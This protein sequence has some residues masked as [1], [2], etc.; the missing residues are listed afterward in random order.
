MLSKCFINDIQATTLSM[1]KV[2]G[3]ICGR[4]DKGLLMALPIDEKRQSEQ[5][6]N[7]I[8]RIP[9]N[10]ERNRK[11]KQKEFYDI[12]DI[13]RMGFADVDANSGYFFDQGNIPGNER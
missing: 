5:R 11:L 9:E 13:C 12:L 1:V 4:F 10:N 3:R 6:L 7:Q 2:E 8:F